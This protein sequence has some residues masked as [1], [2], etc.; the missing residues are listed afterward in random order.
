MAEGR[1]VEEIRVCRVH[2]DVVLT[3]G[4]D[5]FHCPKCQEMAANHG[6][7]VAACPHCHESLL[8]PRPSLMV[9][10]LKPDEKLPSVR[11]FWE[12]A[13]PDL[14]DGT[15]LIYV[16]AKRDIF[17]KISVPPIRVEPGKKGPILRLRCPHCLRS[18][19]PALEN[20]TCR[21]CGAEVVVVDVR[22][23]RGKGGFGKRYVCSRFGCS[24]DHSGEEH[25][26]G[27]DGH[28]IA[29]LAN[30]A[31]VGDTM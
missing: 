18:L 4:P 3:F 19:P 12:D 16:S 21:L 28:V 5:G 30:G 22:Y 23:P 17:E 27:L 25:D 8:V 24:G 1:R 9:S 31:L 6:V 13:N 11:L 26:I 15:H 2:D 10:G 20:P 14:Y 7:I 29:A